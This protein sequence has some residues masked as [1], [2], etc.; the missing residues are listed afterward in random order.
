MTRE[1]Y[2]SIKNEIKQL[3]EF[4]TVDILVEVLKIMSKYI[5]ESDEE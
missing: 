2:E 5:E 4:D 3:D 1:E